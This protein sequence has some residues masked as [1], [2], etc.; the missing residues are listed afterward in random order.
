MMLSLLIYCCACGFFSS[1]RIERATWENVCVR[2]LTADTHPDH[3][4]MCKFRKEN[5]SAIAMAFLHVLFL[6]REMDVLRVGTISI[7]GTKIDANASK[8]KN[9]HY[10]RAGE[11]EEKLEKDIQELLEK[12]EDADNSDDDDARGLKGVKQKGLTPAWYPSRL[13][14]SCALR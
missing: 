2:Y 11:F 7:D 9:V 12:A 13:I 1:R 6:A 8:D 5:E 4:T 10:D 3:D 14:M